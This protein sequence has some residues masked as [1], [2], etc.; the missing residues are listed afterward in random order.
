MKRHVSRLILIVACLGGMAC[1]ARGEDPIPPRLSP[2]E[3]LARLKVADGLQVELYAAEPFVR[4]PVTMTFDDQGRMWVIQYLQYPHPAGLA[5]VQVDQYLRTKYDKMPEPPPRGPSGADRVTILEDRDQDGRIDD[6]HDFVTGLNLASGLALGHGGVYVLQAPYLLFYPDRDRNDRPDGDPEVLLSGFGIDDAHA[7]ANS[8]T[9]GPDGWLYGVQGSTVTANVRGNEFQ[10]GCW[11]FHPR[12]QE[13]ELFAEGGGN[14]WGL[15]FD[16]QGNIFAAGNTVEPLVH[17]V[18]GAYYVKGFGKHGPLHNPHAYGYFAPVQHFGFPGDSLTGGAVI[19]QGGL[20]GKSFDGTCIAPN[21]RH[22]AVRWSRLEPMKSTFVTHHGGDFL[23]TEDKWFRPVDITTGP[24][25]ALYIA[26]W[27]DEIISHSDPK[28]RSRYYEPSREDGRIYRVSPQGFSKPTLIE[29]PL[30]EWSS[31][32][33]LSLFK[34]PNDWYARQA[35]QI[36][37]Q[38]RDTALVERLQRDA[39]QDKNERIALESLWSQFTIGGISDQSAIRLLESPFASVRAWT[40]RLIGDAR[41]VS[42]E[43]S[44]ELVRVAEQD[45]SI[46]VRTQLACTAKRLPVADALPILRQLLLHDDDL[47]DPFQP[48]LLWWAIEDK[49]GQHPGAVSDLIRDERVWSSKITQQTILQRLARRWISGTEENLLPACGELLSVA[50]GRSGSQ[51]VL[52]GMELGLVGKL[53]KETSSDLEDPLRQA[54][55]QQGDDPIT[56]RVALRLGK[57]DLLPKARALMVAGDSSEQARIMT[58]ELVGQLADQQSQQVLSDLLAQDGPPAIRSAAL[59][60]LQ[61]LDQAKIG[62]QL[63]EMYPALPAE[64]QGQAI[65]VL[66]SRSAWGL[67]LAKAVDEKKLPAGILSLDQVRQL[68]SHADLPELQSLVEKNWGR[69]R[70]ATPEEKQQ[71]IN[72]LA[73]LLSQGG[74]DPRAGKPLFLK[75]CANCHKLFGEGKEVGPDLN[76]AER[77]NRQVLLSNV[78][79]PSAVI[80]PQYLAYVVNTTD[81]RI[82]TGL[83]AENGENSITLLDAKNVKTVVPRDEIDEMEQS[84]LSLMPDNVLD[85]LGREQI[86]DLFRYV[87]LESGIE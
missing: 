77:K 14:S 52:E 84:P 28:D 56:I 34:L 1:P 81:G 12:T 17:H 11:R 29:P 68:R 19:Y 58:I 83:L 67:A 47:E 53:H 4:Q 61:R 36:L 27:C 73:G 80:R 64:L 71:R 65:S 46:Q 72:T 69:V 35:R 32:S 45:V 25:G 23:T 75:H 6:S 37:A 26:D 18:Q 62:D 57:L 63:L 54:L 87:Q 42:A 8:L 15:D 66:C 79:D 60:A 7:V 51:Q 10:Q 38:R 5:P 55:K 24:D 86:R 59:G 13:F 9:W 16:R 20:L 33:L 48:L 85:P 82:L 70:A 49:A 22:N 31:E 78:V 76:A 21:T 50:L 44:T 40:V 43:M 74:G 39:T 2:E 3:A 30:S 41:Q